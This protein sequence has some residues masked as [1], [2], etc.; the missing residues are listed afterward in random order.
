[1]K[2]QCIPPYCSC[3]LKNYL[4]LLKIIKGKTFSKLH[5]FKCMY[6]L[7]VRAVIVLI[8]FDENFILKIETSHFHE[9]FKNLGFFFL[10]FT[11]TYGTFSV[12]FCIP[13]H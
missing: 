5:F 13:A 9:R 10:A 4:F 6:N 11:V 8:T 2:I 7:F 12:L 3:S 1:M